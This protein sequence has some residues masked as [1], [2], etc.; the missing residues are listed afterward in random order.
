MACHARGTAC[1]KGERI[2][3]RDLYIQNLTRLETETLDFIQIIG[4]TVLADYVN[5]IIS[6]L[7]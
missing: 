7:Q 4:I 5:Y 1:E 6:S 3:S 2:M